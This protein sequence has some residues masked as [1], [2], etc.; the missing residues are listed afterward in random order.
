MKSSDYSPE[1]F[2]RDGSIVLLDGL[3]AEGTWSPEGFAIEIANIL[4]ISVNKRM[5][6]G[7]ESKGWTFEDRGMVYLIPTWYTCREA[8]DRDYMSTFKKKKLQQE[9]RKKKMIF[10]HMSSLLALDDGSKI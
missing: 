1:Y 10:D 5:E 6:K 2:N 9:E 8:W 3:T 7:N 4:D